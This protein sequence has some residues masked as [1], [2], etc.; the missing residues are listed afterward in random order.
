MPLTRGMLKPTVAGRP[1]ACLARRVHPEKRTRWPAAL[2]ARM[3]R[4]LPP[5]RFCLGQR[6]V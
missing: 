2:A 5:D 3:G 1:S 4:N 6:S